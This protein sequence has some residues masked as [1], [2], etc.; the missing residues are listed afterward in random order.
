MEE[1]GLLL[2]RLTLRESMLLRCLVLAAQRLLGFFGR[3]GSTWSYSRSALYFWSARRQIDRRLKTSSADAVFVLNF[4]Y[5]PSIPSPV[6]FFMFCDWSYGYAI[7][8]QRA[9]RPD[10]NEERSIFRE[11]QLIASADCAFVLFPLAAKYIRREVPAA[12]SYYL[13]N[14]INSVEQPDERDIRQKEASLSI[15]FVGKPHYLQGALDLVEAYRVLKKT[16][17][18]LVLNIVGMGVDYFNDLPEGVACHGYLDKDDS[19]QRAKYYELLRGARLFVN[20][21]P[22]WASFS[23]ALEAMYFYTPLVTSAYSEMEETFGQEIAFGA[24]YRGNTTQSLAELVQELM[25]SDKYQ[26]MARKA[27]EEASPF[28]WDAYA[29]QVLKVITKESEVDRRI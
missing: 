25:V 15:L 14:V 1:Q 19:L 4:S 17:P 28:S 12:K 29:Q 24:Y 18:T 21:N 27:H 3:R 26:V 9:R 5:G 2:E 11:H 16:F 20:P 22:K 6:P 8:R 23:A 10:K 7:E 13:G